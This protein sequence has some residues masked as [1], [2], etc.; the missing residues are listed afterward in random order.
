MI[1]TLAIGFLLDPLPKVKLTT[2][3]KSNK[4]DK[5]ISLIHTMSALWLISMWQSVL[6]AVVVINLKGMLMQVREVPYLWRRDKHDCVSAHTIIFILISRTKHIKSLQETVLCV[7]KGEKTGQS[8]RAGQSPAL[9][10]QPRW[11]NVA[12]CDVVKRLVC[13]S[14]WCHKK[15]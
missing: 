14:V 8:Q 4:E 15:K 13:F 5:K 2:F 6:G 10:I 7:W 12:L 1:V 11:H 3:L 9:V